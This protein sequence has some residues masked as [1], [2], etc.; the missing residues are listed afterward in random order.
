METGMQKVF[1]AVEDLKQRAKVEAA[2]GEPQTAQGR[3]VIPVAE[4]RYAFGLHFGGSDDE[5][6]ERDVGASG[7]AARTRPLGLLE[8][9]DEGLRLEPTVD[10]Q[11]IA[12]ALIA[13]GAWLVFWIALALIRIFG[14]RP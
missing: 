14:D 9:D 3:T 7:G 11:K 6:P 5:A 10:E 4:V 13:L 1:D 12:L 8:I 2:F